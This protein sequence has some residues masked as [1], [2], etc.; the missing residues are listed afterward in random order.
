MA[1]AITR[2]LVDEDPYVIVADG[3]SVVK[4]QVTRGHVR[5]TIAGSLPDPAEADFFS[6]PQRYEPYDLSGFTS[7]DKIYVRSEVVG[8]KAEV[9]V[10]TN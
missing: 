5:C 8:E 2:T 10:M 4:L 3:K 7:G 9:V 6:L 1:A